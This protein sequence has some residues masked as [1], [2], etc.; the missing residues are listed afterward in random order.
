MED[1]VDHGTTVSVLIL[2]EEA[3]IA[4]DVEYYLIR[5]GFVVAAALQSCGEAVEWLAE[6][7]PDVAIIDVQLRDGSCGRLAQ[8]LIDLSIPFVV[9]SSSCRR[10]EIFDEALVQG[11]WICKP[12]DPEELVGAVASLLK[13][14]APHA[15]SVRRGNAAVHLDESVPKR[16]EN[17]RVN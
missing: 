10:S 2:E 11:L 3:L 9:H 14:H 4:L 5:S 8:M 16:T 1:P 6:N 13:A 15:W 12:C 17:Q 7:H